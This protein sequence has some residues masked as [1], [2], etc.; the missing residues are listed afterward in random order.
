[1]RAQVRAVSPGEYEK[2]LAQQASDLKQAQ[3]LLALSRKTRAQ[4]GP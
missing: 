3:A 2:W 1:M 4:S